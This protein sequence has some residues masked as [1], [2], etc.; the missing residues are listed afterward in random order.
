[1]CVC[2]VWCVVCGVWC[3]WVSVSV[4]VCVVS[5]LVMCDD[6]EIV[7]QPVTNL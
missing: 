6:G 2:V 5:F 4:C 1:M 3:W 7:K